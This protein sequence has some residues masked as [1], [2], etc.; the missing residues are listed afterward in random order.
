MKDH[1]HSSGP[2]YHFSTDIPELYEETVLRIVPCN[3]HQRYV[4]WELPSEI[5]R[6]CTSLKLCVRLID[7]STDTETETTEYI[8]DSLS[9]HH[10]VTL[11]YPAFEYCYELLAVHAD[12]STEI[13]CST[14]PQTAQKSYSTSPTDTVFRA[15]SVEISERPK[16]MQPRKAEIS[17][18]PKKMQPGKH[19]RDTF[20]SDEETVTP[21]KPDT[22]S[23][24][25]LGEMYSS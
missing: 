24:W 6:K 8:L 17:E 20:I 14:M 23:S 3:P 21:H 12:K 25:S 5:R 19:E 1:S 22:P 2:S 16:E 18:I 4:Y 9:T 10:Y 13:L 15:S 11:A 7:R